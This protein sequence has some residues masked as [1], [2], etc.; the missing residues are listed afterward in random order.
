MFP[1]VVSLLG[2][3]VLVEIIFT[4]RQLVRAIVRRPSQ[5]R[6]LRSYPSVT[7]IRPVRGLDVEAQLNFAAALDTGYPGEV[8]TIFIFDDEGD[9]A[10]PVA[11]EAVRRHNEEGRPGAASVHVAG[12][13]PAGLTGKLHAMMVGERLA[14]GELIAFGD[15]DTR[16]DRDVLRV[17]V[18]ELMLTP[19]A[20]DA[21]AP[22]VANDRARDAGDVGY[23]MLINAWYG[24]AVALAAGPGGELPFIMG[25]L[26]VF[27]RETLHAVGGVGCARGQL[28]DDMAI[29]TCVRNVGLRNIMIEHP[30]HIATGGM[31]FSGFMK[32]FRRWLLFSRNGLPRR[33]TWPMWIRGAEFWVSVIASSLAIAS[34]HLAAAALPAAALVAFSWSLMAI[35]RHFGGAPVPP[36]FWWLPFVIPIAAPACIISTW[37]DRTVDWRGRAYVL[38]AHARLAWPPQP[39]PRV[40]ELNQEL[41]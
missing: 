7:V 37:L 32:L 41:D 27:K 4:H 24:P 33:F 9:S 39:E 13:P 23:S 18:E 20:G 22:V 17:L 5:T 38:D 11:C 10:Y 31:T 21:F 28:V 15:S 34:G 30:L 40:P 19:R 1:V 25:Q 36:R 12:A 14:T 3:A 29:G 8:E 26:M 2:A 6:R 16:P 35:G